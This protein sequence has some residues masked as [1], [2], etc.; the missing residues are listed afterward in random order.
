MDIIKYNKDRQMGTTNEITQKPAI[1]TITGK[2]IQSERRYDSYD[3]KNN[4]CFVELKT[5][6]VN[7]NTYPTTMIT[8]SKLDFIKRYPKMDYYW[9][10]SFKDGLYFHK[11]DSTVNY[12]I[13]MGTRS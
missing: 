1:E 5:R 3:Y 4:K 7:H 6:N 8:A 10:F 12:K 11:Y 9:F 13:A 2:L